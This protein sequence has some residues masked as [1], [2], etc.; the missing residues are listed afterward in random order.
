MEGRQVH[1]F[2]DSRRVFNAMKTFGPFTASLKTF[3][4]NI[5]HNVVIDGL[6]AAENVIIR[7]PE[8][9]TRYLVTWPVFLDAWERGAGAA[10]WRIKP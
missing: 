9:C 8:T 3:D 10:V 6:D 5:A 1:I 7:D 2:D 4:M